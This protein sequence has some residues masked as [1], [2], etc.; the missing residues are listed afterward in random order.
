VL[1]SPGLLF[2][3]VKQGAGAAWESDR[4]GKPRFFQYWSGDA[5]DAALEAAGF[6]IHEASAAETL[7]NTWLTRLALLTHLP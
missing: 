3:S 6:R 7:R 5:L 1:R 4:Y 2:V